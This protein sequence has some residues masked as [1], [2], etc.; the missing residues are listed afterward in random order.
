MKVVNFV[1]KKEKQHRK[2]KKWKYANWGKPRVFGKR[3]I[4]TFFSGV[5]VAVMTAVFVVG[6][7]ICVV[8]AARFVKQAIEARI[9]EGVILNIQNKLEGSRVSHPVSPPVSAPLAIPAAE[10]STS[11]TSTSTTSTTPLSTTT[12]SATIT[13]PSAPAG[14]PSPSNL[15]YTSFTDLFSGNGWINSASTTMYQDINETAF[16]FPPKY[17]WQPI[18]GSPGALEVPRGPAGIT[19]KV[20]QDSGK[21]KILVFASD[22]SEILSAT[23]TPI[24]SD[25]PGSVGVGGTPDDFMVIYGAVTGAGARVA[26]AASGPWNVQDIS[27]YLGMRVMNGGI[28]PAVIRVAQGNSVNWYVWNAA[29]GSP[30]LI[31][32]FTNGTD[33]IQG[34]VDLSGELFTHGEKAASFEEAQAGSDATLVAQITGSSGMVAYYAFT[35]LGFDKSAERFIV[36]SNINSQAGIVVAAS[37]YFDPG[38][39]KNDGSQ[40]DFYVSND[41]TGWYKDNDGSLVSFLNAAGQE[42]LWKADFKPSADGATTPYSDKIGLYYRVKSF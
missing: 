37:F 30:R 13:Q 41:G 33:E 34:A 21:Y 39:F 3:G 19:T 20:I 25:Y 26:R 10:T 9:F 2:R 24:I 1:E 23:S 36:S 27:P 5:G 14:A 22:G 12:S 28:T 8:T 6:L 42:L 17:T 11:P 32:L 7:F 15:V 16:M 18:A 35:D 40:V 31:K 29:A 4:K 38:S